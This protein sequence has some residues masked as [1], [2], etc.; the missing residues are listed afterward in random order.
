MAGTKSGPRATDDYRFDR[1]ILC[2]R[3]EL[4]LYLG[5]ELLTECISGIR[6]VQRQRSYRVLVTTQL[7]W[8][9]RIIYWNCSAHG[10]LPV[11]G[12]GNL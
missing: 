1:F 6:T 10:V 8:F 3:V 9:V 5:H 11:Q 7:Q 2:Q 4:A 12:I